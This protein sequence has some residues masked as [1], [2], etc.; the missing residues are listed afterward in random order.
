MNNFTQLLQTA[1]KSRAVLFDDP[2]TNG[3]RI[4]N[5]GDGVDE[6]TIDYYDNNLLI[7]WY[8]KNIY[9][10]KD[11]I[12]NSLIKTIKPNSIY[13]KNALEIMVLI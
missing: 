4:F 7:T 2:T 11:I 6:I 1:L 8:S 3:F 13:Q 12:V 10:K 9:N 5:D